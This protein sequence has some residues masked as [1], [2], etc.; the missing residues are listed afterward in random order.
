[1]HAVQDRAQAWKETSIGSI[2]RGVLA[3]IAAW[4]ILTDDARLAVKVQ[5]ARDSGHVLQCCQEA[6]FAV[7]QPAAQPAQTQ[8]S[9]PIRVVDFQKDLFRSKTRIRGT[10]ALVDTASG[11]EIF[12][13]RL[14]Q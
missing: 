1:M 7:C 3:Q 10:L 4:D 12:L 14:L 13:E 5:Q 9:K 6:I 2:V 8:R 11:V